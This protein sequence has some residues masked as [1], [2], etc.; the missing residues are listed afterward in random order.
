LITGVI[1]VASFIQKSF[2]N[3]CAPFRVVP[4]E[5]LALTPSSRTN[6]AAAEDGC[7]LDVIFAAIADVMCD[8]KTSQIYCD[9]CLHTGTF[10]ID[11]AAGICQRTFFVTDA[12]FAQIGNL[13]AP[14]RLVWTRTPIVQTHRR[15]E[16]WGALRGFIARI[17]D[18]CDCLQTCCAVFRGN[19][20]VSAN[21]LPFQAT[22]QVAGSA[23]AGVDTFASKRV[24]LGFAHAVKVAAIA[25][26]SGA[27]RIFEVV[28]VGVICACH[29]PIKYSA[30]D[31]LLS[32]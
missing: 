18:F 11:A 17:A 20:T 14:I 27:G 26:S 6:R 19:E 25:E 24:P 8:P 10:E 3:T 31:K 21:T 5:P 7:A 28:A 15:R 1:A 16:S 2:A 4:K 13:I 23:I 29:Q 22:L 12:F 30:L 32:H 9:V